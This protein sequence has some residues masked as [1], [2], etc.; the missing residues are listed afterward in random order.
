MKRR[1]LN[2]KAFWV[3][4]LIVTSLYSIS[5][6]A[7]SS[8][9][10]NIVVP[11]NAAS[12]ITKALEKDCI[13]CT[14]QVAPGGPLDGNRTATALSMV[15]SKT[16]SQEEATFYSN[17]NIYCMTVPELRNEK[18]FKRKML[19]SM[20]K[21]GAGVDRFWQASGCEPRYIPKT[22]SPLIHLIAEN[23]TDRMQY[24]IFLQK[25]Y[26][27][28]R[29][30]ASFKKA[31]NSKN[32][33]GQTVLDYIQYVYS[34]KRFNT[35]EEPGLNAFVKYLCDNGAEYSIYEA[36]KKCPA[37]YMTLTK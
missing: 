5:I 19:E 30:P 37:E 34:N 25:Y 26:T 2:Y 8:R 28:K 18:D 1:H 31:L 29:D 11:R 6:Y 15:S 4:S 21:T 24:I 12:S 3:T 22:S 20:A 10:S 7:F 17:M 9:G 23:S 13:T 16:L 32:S 27:E 14:P 36:S 35:A 33:Q